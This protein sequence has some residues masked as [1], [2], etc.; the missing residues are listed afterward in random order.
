MIEQ[1]IHRVSCVTGMV[2]LIGAFAMAPGNTAFA[3]GCAGGVVTGVVAFT[4]EAPAPRLFLVNKDNAVCGHGTREL[5]DVAVNAEG[6]L[7]NVVVYLDSTEIETEWKH[8]EGGY[9]LEQKGCEFLPHILVFPNTRKVKL[10]VVNSDAVLHNVHLHQVIGRA[11]PTLFNLAQP[12]G[13]PAFQKRLM[14]RGGGRV[15]EVKC[16][17]HDFMQGWIRVVDN[18]HF[19][20]VGEDGTFSISGIPAGEYE[21]KAWH[22]YL[23]EVSQTVSVTD[24][25]T[26]EANFEFVG[27]E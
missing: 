10:R 1:V 6:R 23:G 24:D 15:A 5:R 25:A 27:G 16:D 13:A 22:P 11:K 20:V 2:V 21:F 3:D 9:T 17:A 19:A 8:P 18:P 4:G 14:L 26:S 12:S 7:A